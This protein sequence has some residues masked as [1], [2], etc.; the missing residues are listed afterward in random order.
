MLNNPSGILKIDMIK[1]ILVLSFFVLFFTTHNIVNVFAQNRFQE[2]ETLKVLSLRNGYE[3]WSLGRTGNLSFVSQNQTIN[4]TNPL[5]VYA[6]DSTENLSFSVCYPQGG[7]YCQYVVT[8]EMIDFYKNSSGPLKIKI[9]DRAQCGTAASYSIK[10][11][12]LEK[13]TPLLGGF[14]SRMHGD[15]YIYKK[16][17]LEYRSSCFF[18]AEDILTDLVNKGAISFN[19][20]KDISAIEAV[21][22]I[23]SL[24]EGNTTQVPAYGSMQ[25]LYP[26]GTAY[27]RLPQ[28]YVDEPF[29]AGQSTS[30]S[31]QSR[32]NTL[33]LRATSRN[34]ATGGVQLMW[35]LPTEVPS[36][37]AYRVNV[38]EVAYTEYDA[39]GGALAEKFQTTL[40]PVNSYFLSPLKQNTKYTITLKGKSSVGNIVT[41]D[42]ITDTFLST[43]STRTT[44]PTNAPSLDIKPPVTTLPPV[45]DLSPVVDSSRLVLQVTQQ[46]ILVRGYVE[47]VEGDKL[48]VR[49]FGGYWNVKISPST[50]YVPS[51]SGRPAISVGD[52]VGARGVLS[53]S[54]AYTF[55][56]DAFRNRTLN[57]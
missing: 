22:K 45:A 49:T 35:N 25:T 57:P 12:Y 28:N 43:V 46:S 16:G 42:T 38:F 47:S 56:A 3:P 40:S 26:N 44:N 30:Q 2:I 17:G 23:V 29:P 39:Q 36:S 4:S 20:A 15:W 13:N 1:K 5:M 31:S 27:C 18:N 41:V 8:Q 6:T 32:E 53:S 11:F 48:R 54:E 34:L 9:C 19:E 37:D 33:S 7:S 14:L 10:G 50:T 51:G 21:K 55:T 52:F 24:T